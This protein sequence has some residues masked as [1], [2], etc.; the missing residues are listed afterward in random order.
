MK[1]TINNTEYYVYW[2]HIQEGRYKGTKCFIIDNKTEKMI[3]EGMGVLHPNDN[4]NKKIGR[5]ISLTKALNNYD[6]MMEEDSWKKEGRTMFWN[7]YHKL[8]PY[9]KSLNK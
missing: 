1:V 7:E 5:K 3:I 2:K 4:F 8:F 6:S 9:N